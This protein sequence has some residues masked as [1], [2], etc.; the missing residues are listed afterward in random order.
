M[1]KT[2]KHA[3]RGQG[4]PSTPKR[5]RA[6]RG[7]YITHNTPQRAKVQGTIE[8]LRAKEL[9]I[10]S[11]EVFRF[12]GF[13]KQ[14]G[15]DIIKPRAPA[16]T[17][18]NRDIVE[19]RGRPNKL[20]GADIREADHLLEEADLGLDAKEIGWIGLV[21][22]L[23]LDIHL[24]TLQ[25]IICD[26]MTYRGHLAATKEELPQRTKDDRWAWA[27]TIL[28]LRKDPGNWKNVRWS[29]EFH[30]GF[31]PEGRLWIIRKRGNGI[32]GRF[33][34]IQHTHKPTDT[35][36]IGKVHA[37]A[38]VGWEFK[39]PLIFYTV[40]DPQ[41]AITNKVAKWFRDHG[42]ETFFN[43][44]NSPDLAPIETCW[45]GPKQYQRKGPHWDQET[46]RELLRE[47]WDRVS[48]PYINKLVLSMAERRRDVQRLKGG[49]TSW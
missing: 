13:E 41:G 48:Q 37:W 5:K 42:V 18:H 7:T 6:K 14:T 16:R 43:C 11:T 38:A 10:D 23:D 17:F 3:K 28:S 46:L 32:P 49:K 25:R 22:E 39:T 2:R 34:N 9:P 30:A 47:G 20:S 29:D 12:F 35:Q 4:G 33:D 26:A 15:Y 31:G 44:H 8:F 40:R 19:I 27:D 24:K 36:A 1:P 45:Q 21:W